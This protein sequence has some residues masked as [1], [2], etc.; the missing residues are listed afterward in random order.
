MEK[1]G[2]GTGER[3][4]VR[5]KGRGVEEDWRERRSSE[6]LERFREAWGLEED[7]RENGARGRGEIEKNGTRHR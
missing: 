7:E 3:E 1:K 4:Q 6:K 2:G 5:C